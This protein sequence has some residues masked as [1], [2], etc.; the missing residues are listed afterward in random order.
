MNKEV[1]QIIAGAGVLGLCYLAGY[2]I[3]YVSF[4][5]VKKIK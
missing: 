2:A 5:L 3:G 4:N 1:K